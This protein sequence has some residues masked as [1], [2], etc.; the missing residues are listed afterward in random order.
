MSYFKFSCPDELMPIDINSLKNLFYNAIQYNNEVC[1]TMKRGNLMMLRYILFNGG[2]IFDYIDIQEKIRQVNNNTYITTF[3][4]D[5]VS[6]L[7]DFEKYLYMSNIKPQLIQ[8][9]TTT[10]YQYNAI[11][12]DKTQLAQ[13]IM[14]NIHNT[15]INGN[16]LNIYTVIVNEMSQK[17]PQE[18][19]RIKKMLIAYE[20]LIMNI[21]FAD[22]SIAIE[23]CTKFPQDE[24]SSEIYQELDI[25]YNG[26]VGSKIEADL[27]NAI[28]PPIQMLIQ[29]VQAYKQKL[30]DAN[31]NDVQVEKIVLNEVKNNL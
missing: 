14:D 8:L 24:L 13:E 29:V 31:I 12:F 23:N 16:E 28:Q 15:V 25:Q 10:N 17:N 21:I 19:A 11:E 20:Q 6:L 26:K 7:K 1:F 9:F 18:F 22:L 3:V 4:L 30:A 27:I 5:E 2:K